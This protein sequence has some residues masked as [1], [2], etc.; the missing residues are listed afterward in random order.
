MLVSIR[1]CPFLKEKNMK[2]SEILARVDEIK[3]NTYDDNIK[4]GWLSALDGQIFNDI[5]KTHAKDV[6]TPDEFLGYTNQDIDTELLVGFPHDDIYEAYI[7]AQIDFAN[8]ETE[9]YA[10]SSTMFNNAYKNF[11]ADYNRQHMPN[12]HTMKF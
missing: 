3:P 12:V 10:N 4:I 7:Y 5:I 1:Y 11:R 9:R 8:G 6:N 2:I